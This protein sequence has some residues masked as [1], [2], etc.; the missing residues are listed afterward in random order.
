MKTHTIYTNDQATPVTYREY[1]ESQKAYYQERIEGHEHNLQTALDAIATI[2][3]IS[4]TYRLPEKAKT[5][6]NL[7]KMIETIEHNLFVATLDFYH[8]FNETV[9]CWKANTINTRFAA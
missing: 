2:S 3:T 9:D 1:R 7:R 5:L 6:D 4:G 8:R